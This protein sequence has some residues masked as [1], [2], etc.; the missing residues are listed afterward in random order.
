MLLVT[1]SCHCKYARHKVY[2]RSGNLSTASMRCVWSVYYIEFTVNPVHVST[3]DTE[4]VHCTHPA[5]YLV[6]FIRLDSE[7]KVYQ[8]NPYST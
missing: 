7:T 5:D 1:V 2:S 6:T 8:P 4:Q 3:L